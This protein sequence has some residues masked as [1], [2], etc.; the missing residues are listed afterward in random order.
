MKYTLI[1]RSILI[2]AT[3]IAMVG[4]FTSLDNTSIALAQ[5]A[6]H[7]DHE[8]H[9]SEDNDKDT[10]D[11][12]EYEDEQGTIH[13]GHDVITEFGIKVARAAG[14]EI[15]QTVRLPG[16]VN[17]NADRIAHVTPTVAGIAKQVNFSVGDQVQAGQVMA[18]LNSKELAAARSEYLAANARLELANHNMQREQRLF[19]EKV[20]TERASLESQQAYQEAKI[21]AKQAINSLFALGYSRQQIETI[22]SL[23]DTD[24]NTY[25]L[26]A[27]LSGMITQRHLTVGEVIEPG[28]DSSPFVVADLSTVWVNLSVYQRDL[29]NVKAGQH[30]EIQ[31]GHNLQAAEGTIAFVSP[32]VDEDT[33]TATA[34][35]VLDN[36]DGSRRPGLFV[37]GNIKTSHDKAA[38]VISRAA[39]T[40][41]EGDQVVFV[42]TDE[43]FELREVRFGRKTDKLVEIISGLIPGE[44]YAVNNILALKT[45]L[46][47]ASLEHA[48][49]A[50]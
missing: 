37:T 19:K 12:D 10:E 11:P 26:T 29:A 23:D 20:G 47:R 16:E 2:V 9:G 15:A 25:E 31:F 4:Y 7:S 14:G 43:G 34:R 17:F 32:A 49:H 30:V 1:Y 35:I 46:S 27:P 42:K 41:V 38:V 3:A 24:F 33:R 18:I 40:T 8:E 36:T 22:S 44:Y 5:E 45:E 28:N 21:A 6:G 50:H 39:I 13:I 48:G